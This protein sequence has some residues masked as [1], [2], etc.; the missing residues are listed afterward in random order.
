VLGP[1]LFLLYINDLPSTIE[2]KA[3]TV[4]LYADDTSVIITEPNPL[5]FKLNLNTLIED[6]NTWFTYNLLTL[7]IDKTQ[8]LEFMPS[9]NLNKKG[10]IMCKNN[11]I[12]NT[13][14]STK[15]LGLI[16]DETLSWQPHIE[17]LIKRMCSASYAMRSLKYFLQTET[18]RMLYFARVH[19]LI[20]YG[21]MFWGFSS[22]ATKVFIMQKKFF[23]LCIT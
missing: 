6:I 17:V 2:K 21:I 14:E 10:T 15:F 19:S 13:V 3:N 18:L 8:Y 20:S 1:L 12:L 7:N 9:K 5:D 4:I 16:I 11:H 23:G 22:R